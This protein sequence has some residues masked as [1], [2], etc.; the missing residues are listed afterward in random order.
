MQTARIL[1]PVQVAA[2]FGRSRPWFYAHRKRLEQ[3]GFPR[4]DSELGGWPTQSVDNWLDRRENISSHS[5]VESQALEI[6]HGMRHA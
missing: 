5:S 3:L 6:V 4:K 2:K 1:S